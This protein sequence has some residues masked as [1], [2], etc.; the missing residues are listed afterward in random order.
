MTWLDKHRRYRQQLSPY[1]DGRL[2]PP[3]SRALESHLEGCL[4]CRSELQDLRAT[5]SALRDLP[6]ANVP[7][8]FALTSQQA[9]APPPRPSLP[10]ATAIGLGMRLATAGLAVALAALLVVDLGGLRGE[11]GS[12]STGQPQAEKAAPATEANRS[13]QLDQAPSATGVPGA[14]GETNIG[15]TQSVPA[16]GPGTQ[17]LEPSP[18]PVAG[19]QPAPSPTPEPTATPL[20]APA[21][22]TP[23]AT[24]F[25]A[26]VITG[27]PETEGAA[28]RAAASAGA[29][30]GIDPL[31]AAEIALAVALGLT[32]AAAAALA[33]AARRR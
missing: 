18:T 28:A 9:A 21:A 6:L 27:T 8:S 23:A 10:V 2:L 12:P 20:P 25:S 29:G 33:F 13:V 19:E 17:R 16:G 22:P 7:R 4:A 5:V 32:I 11:G 26:F 14:V 24:P 1:I 3:E 30:G 15:R 31:R